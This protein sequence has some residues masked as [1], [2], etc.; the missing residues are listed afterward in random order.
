[1]SEYDGANRAHVRIAAKEA[2]QREL[3]DAEVL[4]NIMSYP[5]GRG[6]MLG[7]LEACHIFATTFAPNANQT[8]FN[9]GARNIGLMLLNDIMRHCPDNY[10]LMMRERNERDAISDARR[11]RSDESRGRNTRAGSNGPIIGDDTAAAPTQ[12][13]QSGGPEFA[14]DYEPGLQG[15]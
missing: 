4:Q 10:V 1:M 11:Q 2:R 8:A 13:E 3:N 15:E 6:W 9:E 5:A 12:P 14:G 7:K